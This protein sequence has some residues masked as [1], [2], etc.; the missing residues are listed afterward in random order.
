MRKRYF[1]V[2]FMS[3]TRFAYT[4]YTN[5]K[6]TVKYTG[7]RKAAGPRITGRVQLPCL[8]SILTVELP[9]SYPECQHAIGFIH[10][11]MESM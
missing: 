11:N 8:V 9:I 10:I 2:M 4:S 3:F 5:C 7:K 6:N 1:C